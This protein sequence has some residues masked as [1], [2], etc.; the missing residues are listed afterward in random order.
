MAD[1]SRIAARLA[2]HATPTEQAS[3]DTL[4]TIQAPT[5]SAMSVLRTPQIETKES[6]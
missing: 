6:P 5:A 1:S 4:A 3:I 2:V